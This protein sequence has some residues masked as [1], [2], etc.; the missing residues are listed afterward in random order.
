M[1]IRI[2]RKKPRQP[3]LSF[4]YRLHRMLPM[5]TRAKLRLYLD[6]EWIFDRLAMEMSF[7]HY[8]VQDHPFRR[9]ARAFLLEHIQPTSRVLDLGCKRGDVSIFVAEKAQRVVGVDHDEAAIA[10][11]RRT[12]QRENLLFLHADALEYLRSG[13]EHFD[14]L[15]LSHIL[16][17]LDGPEEFLMAFRGHFSHIYIELPDHDRSYLNLYRQDMGSSLVYSDDDHVSEFDRDELR[18]MMKRCGITIEEAEYR[19][20]VQRLWCRT[21]QVPG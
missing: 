17:H 13:V 10:E 12:Y 8:G 2:P 21:T 5:G 4:I 16:E 19:Y 3:L 14:V 15:I 6:L 7:A 20:G 18:T 9:C 11:A 1:G